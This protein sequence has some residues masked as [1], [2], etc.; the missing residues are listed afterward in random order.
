MD[1]FLTSDKSKVNFTLGQ[2]IETT[3]F[4]LHWTTDGRRGRV[5]QR[6][7]GNG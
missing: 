7:R 6:D 2:V 4:D 3:D 1:N 5:T